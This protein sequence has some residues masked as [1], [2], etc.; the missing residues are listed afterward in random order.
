MILCVYSQ[1]M[2]INQQEFES[3]HLN[4]C[5]LRPPVSALAGSAQK[6]TAVS[7]TETAGRG[8]CLLGMNPNKCSLWPSA[9]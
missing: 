9:S 7:S 1:K 4:R 6:G 5:L 3:L 8:L 2:V